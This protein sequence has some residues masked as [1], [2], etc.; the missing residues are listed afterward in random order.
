M[1]WNGKFPLK[2]H[3]AI[4]CPTDWRAYPDRQEIGMAVPC[5]VCIRGISLANGGP[6][7]QHQHTSDE[8]SPPNTA[9]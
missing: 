3:D 8:H 1:A 5:V 9:K 2:P 7:H 4:E 6:L